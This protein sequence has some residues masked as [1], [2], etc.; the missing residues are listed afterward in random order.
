[1]IGVRPAW[2]LLRHQHIG[3]FPIAAIP[4]SQPGAA[5]AINAAYIWVSCRYHTAATLYYILA[6]EVLHAVGSSPTWTMSRHW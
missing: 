5:T 6:K 3:L 2:A 4:P 1:M